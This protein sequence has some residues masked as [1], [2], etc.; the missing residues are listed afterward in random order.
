M[1]KR[2]RTK[3]NEGA[4]MGSLFL[5]TTVYRDLEEYVFWAGFDLIYWPALV[6]ALQH[7]Y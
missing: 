2:E 4:L 7:L 6:S 1:K 5:K 3:W